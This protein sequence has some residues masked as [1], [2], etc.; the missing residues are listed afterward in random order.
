M[1]KLLTVLIAFV[2]SLCLFVGC[3]SNNI[4]DDEPDNSQAVYSDTEIKITAGDTELYAT[5]YDNNT[6]KE[7]VKLLPFTLPTIERSGLAKGVHLPEN[8]EYES[9]LLTRN[10]LLGEIGYWSGGDIAI[11]YNDTRYEQTIVDVVQI[12]R[13]ESGV[14]VFENYSG[15]VTIER[16]EKKSMTYEYKTSELFAS[17]NNQKI[18]GVAYTPI[19]AG[20]N[21]PAII[22]S[23]GYGGSYYS[24]DSFARE[25]AKL[26]Y[27][28]YTFDFRGGSGGSRSDGNTRQMSIFTEE[29]DLKAV[30]AMVQ[31]LEYIDSSRIY[32]FGTS[33]GGLVSA[34]VAADLQNEIRGA[35]LMYPAFVLVDDAKR[36]FDSV[37]EIPDTVQYLGMI[38]GRTYFENL[39]D[40]E[41]YADISRYSKDVLILH[42]DRDGLVPLSYSERAAREYS[43]AE[44]HVISGAGHYFGGTHFNIAFG[45]VK[46][47]LQT[48]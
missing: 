47:Y 3:T 11:F 41:P 40:Y 32:L 34:M 39:L 10:Y 31:T 37:N 48:H 8:L 12:G 1:K 22:I 24:N 21:M 7:F 16:V 45:Y 43:S 13:I 17:V 33:Q 4:P 6:A 9:E 36:R 19:G 27:F 2:L 5:L 15:S 28:T 18:Y 38:V 14:E 30:V 46:T 20:N 25:F 35:M 42:G 29:V 23:H 26:G 44:L